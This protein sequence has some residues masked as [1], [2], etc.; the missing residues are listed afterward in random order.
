VPLVLAVNYHDSN[1]HGYHAGDCYE[2]ERVD[3]AVNAREKV[4]DLFHNYFF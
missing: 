1:R 4:S 3:Y 2:S